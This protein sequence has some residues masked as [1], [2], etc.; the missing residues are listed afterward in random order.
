MNLCVNSG[1]KY[2]LI[3]EDGLAFAP[4]S[5]AGDAG[6]GGSVGAGEIS[7]TECIGS[8]VPAGAGAGAG[9]EAGA[10]VI[11][12]GGSRLAADEPVT[13]A[14]VAVV[15]ALGIPIL[16]AFAAVGVLK[17]E[18][19]VAVREVGVPELALTAT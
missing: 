1:I 7:I 10:A 19:P 11:V 8:D 13:G 17:P 16:I 12:M 4:S 3:Y 6:V 9:G 14:A 2:S 5:G 18:V 15:A